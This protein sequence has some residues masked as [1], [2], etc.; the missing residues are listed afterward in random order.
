MCVVQS[1]IIHELCTNLI[2]LMTDEVFKILTLFDLKGLSSL[3]SIW[4]KLKYYSRVKFSS[5]F[6]ISFKSMIIILRFNLLD[7][8]KVLLELWKFCNL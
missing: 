1:S 3:I 4:M 7:I 2:V 6:K 8:F 5:I